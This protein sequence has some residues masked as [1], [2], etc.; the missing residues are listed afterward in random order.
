[1]SERVFW[2]SFLRV[3]PFGL[4]C[5]LFVPDLPTARAQD[6]ERHPVKKPGVRITFLPPPLEGTLSLGI[7]DKAGKLVR[8]LHREAAEKEFVVG[9]NG[10]ITHWDG[11]DQAGRP[12][13]AGKY[14]ARGYAVGRFKVEGIAFYANDWLSDESLPPV[15][16][17][18]S[19][20]WNPAG[21]LSVRVR[22]P[23]G[24]PAELLVDREGRVTRA[25]DSGATPTAPGPSPEVLGALPGIESLQ[26]S[27]LG[28]HNGV[29]VV[30]KTSVGFQVKEYSTSGE[31][32]RRMSIPSD[33][34]PPVQIAAAIDSDLLFLLEENA[35]LQR[36]RGLSLEPVPERQA[37]PE[38]QSAPA[39]GATPAAEG[40]TSSVWKT[41]LSKSRTVADQFETVKDQLSREK[42]FKP[43]EKLRVRLLPN[44]L[45]K[46]ATQDVDLRLQIDEQGSYFATADGLPLQRVTETPFLKWAVA[47]REGGKAVTF[48]ESN[49]VGVAEFRAHRL[50]NMM[51][52]DAGDYEWPPG[53]NP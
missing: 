28:H 22:Q 12:V 26:A 52:F 45:F 13:P 38:G 32:R 37:E 8:T 35:S 15:E 39:E 7:Y 44:P 46:D 30:D 33:Q 48:F 40:P 25:A 34:P 36:L 29:W 14:A 5:A 42:P 41:F 16:K 21:F 47:G 53:K 17:V 9:L 31:L 50:A 2:S 3:V 51:A 4:L 43:E 49:G 27:C 20:A 24:A 18:E 23:G 19:L 1:M 11:K 10:L 6:E